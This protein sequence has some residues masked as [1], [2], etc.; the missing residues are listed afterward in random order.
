MP[1]GCM[2]DSSAVLRL[3]LWSCG[4]VLAGGLSISNGIPTIWAPAS[5]L[6]VMPG[7]VVAE[8]PLNNPSLPFRDFILGVIASI[9]LLAVFFAWSIPG[10]DRPSIPLRSV[11]LL[12][13]VGALSLVYFA[14]SWSYGVSYQGPLHT[15][16]VAVANGLL[17]VFCGKL[18]CASREAPTLALRTTFH[19]AL[20]VW[21]AW[22]SFPWLGELM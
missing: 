7:F 21:L 2:S 15:T 14:V 16:V 11:I 13:F 18:I 19:G 6:V 3:S 10:H 1:V 17:L 5:F 4:I 22:C 9:P 20:F 8:T 12:C